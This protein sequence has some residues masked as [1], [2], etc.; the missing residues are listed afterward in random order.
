MDEL[1]VPHEPTSARA[2]DTIIPAD[3]T[4]P[5][6]AASAPRRYPRVRCF[7]AVQ[8]RAADDQGMLLGKLSDVS[9]GGCGVESANPVKTGTPIALSPLASDGSLWVQGVV[10]NTRLSEGAGSFCIGVRFLEESPSTVHNVQEFVRFVEETT[11]KQAPQDPY[12]RR[13]R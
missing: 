2:G 3:S 1:R 6:V 11:A 10:V 13:T 9:P 5:G 12:L 8:L 7:L 4:Q